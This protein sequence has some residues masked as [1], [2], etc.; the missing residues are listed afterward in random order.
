VEVEPTGD[1]G[2]VPQRRGQGAPMAWRRGPHRARGVVTIHRG[3]AFMGAVPR[4]AHGWAP[5]PH[6]R[7]H[8]RCH[9]QVTVDQGRVKLFDVYRGSWSILSSL[10]Y[11]SRMSVVDRSV[12][13]HRGC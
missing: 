2:P 11:W 6:R 10:Y 1:G 13:C 12:A 3:E 7:R 9:P 4:A 8:A 5:L